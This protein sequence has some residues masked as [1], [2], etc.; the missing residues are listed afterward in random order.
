MF[1]SGQFWDFCAPRFDVWWWE[2]GE[3]ITGAY[4]LVWF[5]SLKLGA[6]DTQWF[7]VRYHQLASYWIPFFNI[8]PRFLSLYARSLTMYIYAHMF[9]L[10]FNFV[11][12]HSGNRWL[13]LSAGL[14]G[15]L[16]AEIEWPPS[17]PCLWPCNHNLMYGTP[18]FGMPSCRLRF[19]FM[20]F[21]I[22]GSTRRHL[23]CVRGFN[24]T[25]CM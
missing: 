19:F 17:R 13:V 18:W 21:P 8:G 16:S 2:E 4:Y 6:F 3:Q 7:K 10:L 23:T 9:F 22:W 14:R 1:F 15:V 20:A 5:L 25:P 11:F 24:T 12:I